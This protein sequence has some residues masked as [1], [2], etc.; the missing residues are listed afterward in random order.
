M[1]TT[2]DGTTDVA[3]TTGPLADHLYTGW[4]IIAN[5]GP[6]GDRGNWDA[7]DPEWRDAAV[8]WRDRFHELLEAQGRPWWVAEGA[9]LPDIAKYAESE[10]F[11]AGALSTLPPFDHYHPQWCLPLARQAIDALSEWEPTDARGVES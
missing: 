3:T 2:H 11:V 8:R 9:E 4:T 7:M 10:V 5:A 6:P 1:S